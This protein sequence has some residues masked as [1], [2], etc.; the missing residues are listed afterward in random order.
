MASSSGNGPPPRARL[1]PKSR[2]GCG[3]ILSRCGRVRGRAKRVSLPIGD[4]EKRRAVRAAAF[5]RGRSVMQRRRK[6]ALTFLDRPSFGECTKS[7]R[8]DGPLEDRCPPQPP[9]AFPTEQQKVS[10]AAEGDTG[11]LGSGY[12]RVARKRR[13]GRAAE[14]FLGAIG[15]MSEERDPAAL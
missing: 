14:Q 3:C 12:S 10:G 13:P 9:E 4:G 7:L 6:A 15:V 5:S 1:P 8:R 11:S 2:L